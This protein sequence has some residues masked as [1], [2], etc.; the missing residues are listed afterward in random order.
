M[1]FELGPE[2]KTGRRGDPPPS[3]AFGNGTKIPARRRRWGGDALAGALIGV[4]VLASAVV[5]FFMFRMRKRRDAA[6]AEGGAEAGGA[7]YYR[8]GARGSRRGRVRRV[9]V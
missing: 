6:G 8:L 5:I 2:P 9:G 4:S 1:H 7:G 3:P